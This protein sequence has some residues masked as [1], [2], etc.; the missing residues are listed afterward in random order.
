MSVLRTIP[1]GFLF[2][3]SL[4]FYFLE[5][6]PT[7]AGTYHALCG[8]AKCT[9]TLSPESIITPYG[10]MPTTRVAN[11]GGTGTTN[12][13]LVLGAAATYVLGPVGLLGFLAKTHDYNYLITGYDNLGNRT[14]IQIKFQNS[15]PAQDFVQEMVEVTGLGMGQTR[16]A[17]EIKELEKRVAVEGISAIRR[18]SL[19]LEQEYAK[20][21]ST[22]SSALRSPSESKCW[23]VYIDKNPD[24]KKWANSNP[25]QAELLRKKYLNC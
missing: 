3:L 19:N 2:R 14:S 15:V 11:W 21:N 7:I 18:P 10:I 22:T 20:E 6:L 13:D 5:A 4:L 24:I 16:T 17:T 9:I 25:L 1:M 23:S 8:T 12:Q